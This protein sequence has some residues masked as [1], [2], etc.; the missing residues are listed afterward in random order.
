MAR[1]SSLLGL[2]SEGVLGKRTEPKVANYW[3]KEYWWFLRE[4]DF[5]KW[6]RLNQYWVK[7]LI[8]RPQETLMNIVLSLRCGKGADF[9]GV[10]WELVA[11]KQTILYQELFYRLFCN[12]GCSTSIWC[13]VFMPI[14]LVMLMIKPFIFLCSININ[15]NIAIVTTFAN[16]FFTVWS[17]PKPIFNELKFNQAKTFGSTSGTHITLQGNFFPILFPR[18]AMGILRFCDA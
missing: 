2:A 6:R 15:N 12:F 11:G 16:I 7:Q 9:F 4:G 18:F 3:F 8:N 17:S 10:D 14:I 13:I 5:D 1:K